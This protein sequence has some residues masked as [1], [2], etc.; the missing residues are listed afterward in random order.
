MSTRD[1][2]AVLLAVLDN[3]QPGASWSSATWHDEAV[4]AQLKYGEIVGAQ[5]RA[6]TDGFLEPVGQWI[7][8][9]WS[10]NMT[11]VKHAAGDGR[12]VAL[13][14]RTAKRVQPVPVDAPGALFG[15][16]SA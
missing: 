14:S 4:L 16:W 12:W 13:Y 11:R 3:A 7:D 15:A 8:G 10:P 2:Y 1:P 6:V 5:K 9:E